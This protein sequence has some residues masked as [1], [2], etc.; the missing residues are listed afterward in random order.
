MSA[1]IIENIEKYK[2]RTMKL[3][4]S[5]GEPVFVNADIIAAYS[6][7]AGLSV[8]EAALKEILAA[9]E[10][11]KAR[12]RALY[13]LD[14][15]DYSYVEMVNKLMNN[16]SE[17]TCYEVADELAEKGFINDRRYAE[18]LARRLCESKLLG[19]FRAKPYMRERG[20]PMRIIEDAL[21]E[22]ADSAPERAAQLA[23]KKYMKYFDPSD[24]AMMQKLKNALVRSGYGFRDIAEA[25]ELLKEEYPGEE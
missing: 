8:P 11:R 21:A 17:D 7:K 14:C 15:R 19:Y 25:V 1:V 2:G 4:L 16:Y 22:Y 24:R 6:L 10:K 5:E 23:E 3:T 9:D 20:I 13:L 18:L 12:E